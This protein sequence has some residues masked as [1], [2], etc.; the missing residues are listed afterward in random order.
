MLGH[1]GRTRT[2]SQMNFHEYH[3]KTE[4]RSPS[5]VGT[6]ETFRLVPLSH[7]ELFS[8]R[9]QRFGDPPEV[10]RAQRSTSMTTNGIIIRSLS[11]QIGAF[12]CNEED[13]RHDLG[14]YAST[15]QKRTYD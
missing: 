6:I 12:R 10:H 13:L 14:F 7:R 11:L 3:E 2:P 8:P 15:I 4:V 9:L 5:P 1:S